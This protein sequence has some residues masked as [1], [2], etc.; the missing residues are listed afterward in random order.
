MAPTVASTTIEDVYPSSIN[1][2]LTSARDTPSISSSPTTVSDLSTVPSKYVYETMD[3]KKRAL[4]QLGKV[5]LRTHDK[6]DALVKPV[7]VF[8]PPEFPNSHMFI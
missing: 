7:G 4:K 6:V 5:A 2:P 3:V 8:P 1:T